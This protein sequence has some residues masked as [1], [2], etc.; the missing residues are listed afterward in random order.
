MNLAGCFLILVFSMQALAVPFLYQKDLAD[1][2]SSADFLNA[3]TDEKAKWLEVLNSDLIDAEIARA[4]VNAALQTPVGTTQTKH[5]RNITIFENPKLAAGS[6]LPVRG[7][8]FALDTR[9]AIQNLP[10]YIQNR[11]GLELYNHLQKHQQKTIVLGSDPKNIEVDLQNILPKGKFAITSLPS[12]YE[13]WGLYRY[14]VEAKTSSESYF[15]LLVPPS[16]QYIQHYVSLLDSAA[17]HSSSS[18]YLNVNAQ[19]VLQQQLQGVAQ[20]VRKNFGDLSVLFFGY[21]KNWLDLLKQ[22]NSAFKLISSTTVV[23]PFGLNLYLMEIQNKSNSRVIRM[24]S[25][26][27]QQTVWGELASFYFKA[28]LTLDPKIVLFMGSAGSLSP[29]IKPYQVSVPNEFTA[30]SGKVK[31]KNWILSE[32]LAAL[33][34]DVFTTARHGNTYSP[35]QQEKSYVKKLVE[36]FVETVDVEQ[37]LVARMI[38]D[39]NESHHAKI[40]FGAINVVTDQPGGVLL[41]QHSSHHD[42]DVL[43]VQAKTRAKSKAAGIALEALKKWTET[44]ASCKKLLDTSSLL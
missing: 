12:L 33:T 16:M 4:I 9:H 39:Y 38:E 17:L 35:I 34:P 24:G 23:T 8:E 5:T 27:P 18:G 43:D 29:Q 7:K 41:P 11:I 36:N 31:I 32:P 14:W 37:T 3:T 19:L 40:Q 21:E 10:G 15:V 26:Q 42:L 6:Y 2:I 1:E 20:D 25:L 22:E 30:P 44:P 28:M 13:Q